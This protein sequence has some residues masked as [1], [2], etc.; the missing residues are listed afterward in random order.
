MCGCTIPSDTYMIWCNSNGITPP[1][2]SHFY[3]D[4]NNDLI[5][6][7]NKNK[8]KEEE[9]EE[10]TVHHKNIILHIEKQMIL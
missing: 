4:N 2:C 1:F 6:L 8:E 5:K 10:N 9:G 7:V 3:Y